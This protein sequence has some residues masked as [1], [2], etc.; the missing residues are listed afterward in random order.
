ML[1]DAMVSR[2]GDATQANGIACRRI[3]AAWKDQAA[4]RN[5]DAAGECARDFVSR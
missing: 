4:F 3:R 1:P 2:A 5:R